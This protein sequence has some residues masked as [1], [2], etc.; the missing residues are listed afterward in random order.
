MKQSIG[1]ILVIAFLVGISAVNGAF[2][3]EPSERGDNIARFEALLDRYPDSDMRAPV[4]IQLAGLYAAREKEVHFESVVAYEDGLNSNRPTLNYERAIAAYTEIIEQYPDFSGH[5]EAVY[6]LAVCYEDMGR[7]DRAIEF[8]EEIIMDGEASPYRARAA[9]RV[10]DLEFAAENWREALIAYD[11]AV[12][13]GGDPARFKIDYKAGWCHLKTNSAL[14]AG[15]AFQRA[16]DRAFETSGS[17]HGGGGLGEVLRS[18]ALVQTE[19]NPDD[20]DGFAARFEDPAY[21]RLAVTAL[22]DVLLDQDRSV[23]AERAYRSVL[24]THPDEDDAPALHDKIIE[25]LTVRGEKIDAG[26][27]ME[28]FHEKYGPTGAWRTI[29]RHDMD[30]I[31]D[32]DRRVQRN[33]WNAALIRYRAGGDSDL[34]V[35]A[36]LFE[37][38]VSELSGGGEADRALLFAAEAWYRLGEFESSIESYDRIDWDALEADEKRQALRGAFLALRDGNAPGWKLADGAERYDAQDRGEVE[39]E[40]AILVAAERLAD[41][42]DG[43]RS[44]ALCGM[45]AAREDSPLRS[46]AAV[47]AGRMASRFDQQSKAERYYLLAAETASDRTDRSENMDR[48][49]A[50]AFLAANGM[51]DGGRW[52]EAAHAYRTIFE[53]YPDSDVRLD[54][55]P[56]QMACLVRAGRY[57]HGLAVA[58]SVVVYLAGRDEPAAEIRACALEAEQNGDGNAAARFLTA[59]HSLTNLPRDLLE[60]SRAFSRAGDPSRAKQ[61]FEDV[62]RLHEG[63]GEA[64]SALFHLAELHESESSYGEAAAAFERCAGLST[65][66][67]AGSTELWV[68]AGE[69][70]QLENQLEVAIRNYGNGLEA[71][72]QTV[73]MDRVGATPTEREA[74]PAARAHFALARNNRV[75]LD[76]SLANWRSGQGSSGPARLMQETVK[77]YRAGI[78]LHFEKITAPAARELAHLLEA[79]GRAAFLREWD[80]GR[81]PDID[82]LEPY[83]SDAL[84]LRETFTDPTRDVVPLYEE[85]ADSLMQMA[86]SALDHASL[87]ART[88]EP[89]EAWFEVHSDAL[90]DWISALNLAEDRWQAAAELLGRQGES[91]GS[92]AYILNRRLSDL[93]IKAAGWNQRGAA[94][95]RQAPAPPGLSEEELAFYRSLLEEKATPFEERGLRW[96]EE[97][98]EVPGGPESPSLSYRM[99]ENRTATGSDAR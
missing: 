47:R 60:A 3:S 64:G 33:L 28:L 61:G 93:A 77:H 8:Y 29:H 27:E 36:A 96:M 63:S 26:R 89:D 12:A 53:N 25:C 51:E 31:D 35:A 21:R 50:S 23:Q 56:R 84:A 46:E 66:P 37:L 32:T 76:S 20:L 72:D 24:S 18:L 5:G 59:S 49:A 19:T 39:A 55:L 43:T 82:L 91:E 90:V 83:Y 16:A 97:I 75:S 85:L 6:A 15:Y 44:I 34:A 10:G 40:K 57:Q 95:L 78:S 68:R 1:M 86:S 22:A 80:R 41:E 92:A 38:Y 13:W 79:Y 71:Y 81:V 62:S 74:F 14:Q 73:S 87:P 67:Q 4:L 2:G 9:V 42:G 99:N 45:I 58:E 7:N 69:N 11:S 65:V 17:D 48:A 94:E 54:A 30:R 70:R 88:D 98:E 52:L